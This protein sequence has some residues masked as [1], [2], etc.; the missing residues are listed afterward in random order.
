M[1]YF[2][3]E[4][5]LLLVV[6][7]IGLLLVLK[8]V[9]FPT[10]GT[11]NVAIMQQKGAIKTVDTQ[12]KLS[13]TKHISVDS[14]NF[15]ESRILEH[16]NLGKLGYTSNIFLKATTEMHVETSGEY[17]FFVTS[18]D[19]FRLKI[20][21]VAVCEHPGDRPM[22]TTVCKKILNKKSH[23]FELLYFQGGGPMGLHVRYKFQGESSSHFIGEASKNMSF[24]EIK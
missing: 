20:D 24:K 23:R 4:T 13:S 1:K 6:L 18:D 22:R 16:P 11:V 3:K 5:V 15:L 2:N 8:T 10:Y 7:F 9:K 17:T 12:Q 19:G 21:G 14:L